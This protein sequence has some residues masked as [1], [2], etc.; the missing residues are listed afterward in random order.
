MFPVF[1]VFTVIGAFTQCAFQADQND[2]GMLALNQGQTIDSFAA[3]HQH[4][5]NVIHD[6]STPSVKHTIGHN[7]HHAVSG[8]AGA[9]E[10]NHNDHVAIADMH[11]Y[12]RHNL[13]GLHEHPDS[14]GAADR[15]A[16]DWE[17][18]WMDYEVG[19]RTI[20]IYHATSKHN[21]ALRYTSLWD[22]HKVRY[23]DWERV[24]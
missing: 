2:A 9:V 1:I 8:V 14:F 24:H 15:W 10:H 16:H 12:A 6:Q 21:E 18:R 11:T 7:G 3:G 17:L 4:T 13:G 19:G 5:P 22:G 20:R 23:H